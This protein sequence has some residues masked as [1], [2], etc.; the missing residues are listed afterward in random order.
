MEPR[1]AP[2]TRNPTTTDPTSHSRPSDW[3]GRT[4]GNKA[5]KLIISG[6]LGVVLPHPPCK[7]FRPNF[8]PF[9]RLS[10]ES[11]GQLSQFSPDFSQVWSSLANFSQALSDLVSFKQV[12]QGK[13][14]EISYRQEGGAKQHPRRERTKLK[15]DK[16]H[17]FCGRH[18]VS[19]ACS[20]DIVGL[21][22]QS[23]TNFHRNCPNRRR[24]KCRGACMLKDQTLKKTRT[25]LF[26]KK[27]L[28]GRNQLLWF[29]AGFLQFPEPPAKFPGHPRFLSSKPKQDKLSREGT[30]FSATTPSHGRSPPPPGGLRTQQVG[31]QILYT[32]RPVKHTLLGGGGV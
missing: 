25:L 16:V 23:P 9:Y 24:I 32:L 13:N 11:P 10:L 30:N 28:N 18:S 21:N 17:S 31:G 19:T 6:E 27:K 3:K 20:L 7:I 14:A 22:G 26:P 12:I 1:D 5:R 2:K 29:P 15:M 4:W 8:S